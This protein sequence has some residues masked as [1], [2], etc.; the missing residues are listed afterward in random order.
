MILRKS[1]KY[2]WCVGFLGFSNLDCPF[3]FCVL[4]WGWLCFWAHFVKAAPCSCNESGIEAISSRCLLLHVYC[5]VRTRT[6]LL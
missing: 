1:V 3:R 2:T 6:V 5:A 4:A